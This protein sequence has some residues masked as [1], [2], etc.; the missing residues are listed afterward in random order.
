VRIKTFKYTGL[1]E[2]TPLFDV[3]EIILFP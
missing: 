2:S 1:T 3:S